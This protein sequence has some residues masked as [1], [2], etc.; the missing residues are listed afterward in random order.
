MERQ[1]TAIRGPV[2]LRNSNKLKEVSFPPW[3][4]ISITFLNLNHRLSISVRTTDIRLKAL[5]KKWRKRETS[6]LNSLMFTY[7]FLLDFIE[8]TMWCYFLRFLSPPSFFVGIF[9]K[10]FYPSPSILI[11]ILPTYTFCRFPNITPLTAIKSSIIFDVIFVQ[12]FI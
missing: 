9:S 3:S 11:L 4:I 5:C 8:V 10:K 1:K 6:S 12:T 2:V 7:I